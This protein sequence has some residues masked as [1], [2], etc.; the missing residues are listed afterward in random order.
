MI[1]ICVLEKICK[2]AGY[3]IEYKVMLY[4]KLVDAVNNHKADTA[5][6]EL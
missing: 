3:Q 4:D 2:R 1:N 6:G 5:D